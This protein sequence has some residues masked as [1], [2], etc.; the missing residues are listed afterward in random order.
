MPRIAR[1]QSMDVLSSLATIAG[2]KSV[3][4]AA[5]QL[6]KLFPMMTTAAGTIPPARL[7]EGQPELPAA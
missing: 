1:A 6:P 4:L 5:L 3:L 7:W 2:Y